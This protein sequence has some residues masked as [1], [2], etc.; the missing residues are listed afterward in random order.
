MRASAPRA[1]KSNKIGEAPLKATRTCVS[2]RP[3]RS[4]SCRHPHSHS[5]P[6]SACRRARCRLPTV[7]VSPEVQKVIALPLRKD[8]DLL[9]KTGEEWKPIVEAAAAGVIKNVIPGLTRADEGEG[10]ADDDR[11]REGLHRDARDDRAGQSRTASLMHLHGGGYALFPRR[12]RGR[13]EGNADGGAGRW[14][15][16]V[17]VDYRMALDLIRSRRRW[18]TRLGGL[19]ARLPAAQRPAV[20]GRCSARGRA[21]G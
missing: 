12:G 5:N 10:R 16:V 8:W 11:R 20:D 17:S 21:A 19:G 13:C 15:E 14:L 9:P 6:G 2:P 3:R 7:D 4:R 1:T 18:R